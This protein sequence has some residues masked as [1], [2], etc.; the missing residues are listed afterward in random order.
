[1]SKE[2]VEFGFVGTLWVHT[3]Q[4]WGQ[5]LGLFEVRSQHEKGDGS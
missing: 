3:L 5:L 1:M 2:G 4:P